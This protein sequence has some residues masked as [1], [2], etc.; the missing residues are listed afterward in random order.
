MTSHPTATEASMV[1]PIEPGDIPHEFQRDVIAAAIKAA[2][3]A[4]RQNCEDDPAKAA[5]QVAEA[6]VVAWEVVNGLSRSASPSPRT[7]G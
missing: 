3:F 2:A 1:N 5:R 7:A 4:V 6:A